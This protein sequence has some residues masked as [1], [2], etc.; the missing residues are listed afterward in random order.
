[1]KPARRTGVAA[2]VVIALAG[3]AVAAAQQ[4]WRSDT[5]GQGSGHD[6]GGAPS[7]ATV[8]R[9]TL[10]SGLELTG[11]LGHGPATDVVGQGQGTFT[12]LPRPGDRIEAGGV[13]YELNGEPVVLFAGSRPFWRELAT[14]VTGPDVQEL[15]RNL[16]DL[17]YADATSMTVDE[18]FTDGTAAAVKRWQKAHG[19]KRTGRVELGRVVVLRDRAVRVEEVSAKLGGTA[20]AGSGTT[21]LKVTRPGVFATVGLDDEQIAQ[22]APGS[23]V[24]VRLGTGSA[25]KGEVKQI[26]R[27]SGADGGQGA[28]DDATA[29]GGGGAA[30]AGS[31]T[32]GGQDKATA[33][34][35]LT[36]QKK[37]K[38]ALDHARPA[39][40]L[41]VPEDKAEDTLVVPVTALLAR[42]EGGYG[43]EVV[44]PGAAQPVRVRVRV[45][46]IVDARAQITPVA[47]RL[48]EGD[49]VVI[50]S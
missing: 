1:M 50:P 49:K 38:S 15:E 5:R 48:S 35:A 24:T 18:E 14:G 10:T 20:V 26:T 27:G 17:G 4:P 29:G 33:T 28:D 30:G 44:R 23:K 16:T 8:Q 7:T 47:G 13:L 42:P 40:T 2:A 9:T 32:A 21:V 36:D 19:L 25:T 22:L 45:G 37:A 31:G 11:K 39:V 46:L 43:V 41:T 34:I 12:G 6:G 3:G